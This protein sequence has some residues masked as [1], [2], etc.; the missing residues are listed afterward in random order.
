MSTE[1]V[2]QVENEIVD[3]GTRLLDAIQ[4]RDTPQTLALLKQGAPIW[5]QEQETGWSALH[6]AAH[7][8][9]IELVEILIERGAI[10]NAS[11]F[12]TFSTSLHLLRSSLP[13]D[14]VPNIADYLG[15][16]PADIALSL[17]NEAIYQR[18]RDA[19]LRSGPH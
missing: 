7:Y 13:P 11:Q 5:F 9:D 3:A 2:Q 19:G 6:F 17:N 4:A 18:V 16:T 1:D 12:I 15:N 14:P 10:W 8:E